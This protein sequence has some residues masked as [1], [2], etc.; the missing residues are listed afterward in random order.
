MGS[1]SPGV[2][3]LVWVG[4]WMPRR[5][6]GRL[7]LSPQDLGGGGGAVVQRPRIPQA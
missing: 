4:L 7:V 3:L 5:P 1:G 6:P 2:I